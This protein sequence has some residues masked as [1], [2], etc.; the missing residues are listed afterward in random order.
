MEHNFSAKPQLAVFARRPAPGRVK[1]RLAGTLG[2]ERAAVLYRAFLADTI[3]RA[4]K[5][6]PG[7][8]TLWLAPEPERS[9][10]ATIDDTLAALAELGVGAV[11]AALQEGGDLGARMAHAFEVLLPHGPAAIVG[12]DA[13]DLPVE[14]LAAAFAAL[15]DADL[16]LGPTEDGGYYLVAARRAVGDLFTG[17]TWST[18]TTFE[19][20]AQRAHARGWKL[21]TLAPWR[22]VDDA[23]DFAAL[24]TRLA[25][26]PEQGRPRHTAHAI[27]PGAQS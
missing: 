26:M 24:E 23:E 16:V 22:D 17:V 27:T 9:A 2:A 21:A 10:R 12:S 8:V 19:E 6:A 7:A 14:F 18:A 3:E 4:H 1:T 20:T 11:P 13:P 15:G 5:A 25:R